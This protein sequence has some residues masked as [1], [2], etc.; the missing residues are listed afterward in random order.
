MYWPFIKWRLQSLQKLSTAFYKLS[1][2][3]GKI[4]SKTRGF[5][6]AG[7]LVGTEFLVSKI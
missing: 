5:D 1:G 6:A 4:H 2:I 7:M 3:L